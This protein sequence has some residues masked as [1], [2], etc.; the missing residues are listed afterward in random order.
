MKTQTQKEAAGAQAE[1]VRGMMAASKTETAQAR[2]AG[3]GKTYD[4]AYTAVFA[5]LIAICSWISIPTVVPF[6]LQTFAVFLAVSVL[7]GR[8]GT[9]SIVVY[10]D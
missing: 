7:G 5:V 3:R 4:M 2:R 9:L 6:T 8:R 1:T 10:E